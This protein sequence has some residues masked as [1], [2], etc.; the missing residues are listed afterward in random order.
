[1]TWMV[2]FIFDEG[3][4]TMRPGYLALGLPPPLISGQGY[5]LGVWASQAAKA[6]CVSP[7]MHSI[8]LMFFHY[9]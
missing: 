5:Y 9:F 4:V 7:Y 8:L 2:H 6:L 3:P 1:M